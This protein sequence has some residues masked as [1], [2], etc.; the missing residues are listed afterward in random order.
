MANASHLL[1]AKNIDDIYFS[2]N[3]LSEKTMSEVNEDELMNKCQKINSFSTAGRLTEAKLLQKLVDRVES[4]QEV[5]M[6]P[7]DQKLMEQK[8]R[9]AEQARA[10]RQKKKEQSLNMVETQETQQKSEQKDRVCPCDENLVFVPITEKNPNRDYGFFKCAKNQWN[11]AEKKYG[12]GCKIWI[13]END[14]G[15]LPDCGCGY[16]AAKS[17]YHDG[18]FYCRAKKCQRFTA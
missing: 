11:S 16:V 17:Q 8:R 9:K 12:G 3:T 10:R 2:S 18:E 15:T 4:K 7:D 14:L 13:K 1:S 6:E 5:Q